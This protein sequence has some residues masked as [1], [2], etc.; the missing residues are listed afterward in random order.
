M[1]TCDGG[2][3]F[4]GSGFVGGFIEGSGFIKSG[5]FA[6]GGDFAEDGGFVEGGDCCTCGR[7]SDVAAKE[8]GAKIQGGDWRRR[9]ESK[10]ST[11]MSRRQ[12]G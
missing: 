5:G 4:E 7:D 9:S 8:T 3:F 10:A 6:T 2:G 11:G 1:T 12:N